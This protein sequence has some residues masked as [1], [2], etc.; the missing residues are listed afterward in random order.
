MS[1]LTAGLAVMSLHPAPVIPA[2]A[3]TASAETATAETPVSTQIPAMAATSQKLAPP[4]QYVRVGEKA[5]E[6]SAIPSRQ[7]VHEIIQLLLSKD[8]PFSPIDVV[9]HSNHS[10][11]ERL[12]K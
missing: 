10:A 8:C 1:Q 9:H 7:Q 6:L 2:S 3:E 11:T 12:L 5:P 4:T